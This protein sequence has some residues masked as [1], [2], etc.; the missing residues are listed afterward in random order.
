MTHSSFFS[1][2][3]AVLSGLAL[4]GLVSSTAYASS[5]PSAAQGQASPGRVTEQFEDRFTPSVSPQVEVT[6]FQPVGAPAN[7]DQISLTLN[8]LN[9]EGV[10]VYT[11][12]DL[13]AIYGNVLGQ[14]ITLADLYGIANEIT[15]RYRNDGFILTQAIIPP[16]TIDG[17]T[18]TIRVVEGFVDSVVVEGDPSITGSPLIQRMANQISFDGALNASDLERQLLL[19]NDLPGVSARSVLSPSPTVT[20]AADLRL[21][22]ER[23]PFDGLIGVD[24]YGSRYLGPLQTTFIGSANNFFLGFNERLTGQLVLAPSPE[25]ELSYVALNYEQPIWSHGTML[26]IFLS[27]T[28]TEP[29]F[30]LEQF[31]VE[32]ES[33]FVSVQVEHPFVRSRAFN[34]YGRALLDWRDVETVNNLND[35]RDDQIVAARIGT[36]VDFLDT[37]L[38]VAFN[39]LDVELAHGLD[40]L[41][42]TDDGSTTLSRPDGEPEFFKISGEYQR[43]QNVTR[44]INVLLG[45]RGQWT[46]EAL[47]SS[48]EFGFGGINYGRGFDSS[49]IIGDRGVAGKLE[50]Q[51]D[52]PIQWNLVQDYQ[53]FGFFDAGRVWND[54]ATTSSFK[55]DSATSVG[56]GVRME[57][58]EETFADFMIAKP[59]NRDVETTD[60]DD[61][62]F[63]FSLRREF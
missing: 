50:I 4:A 32:G 42:A 57:F 16:Q 13:E 10:T 33:N 24:N 36:R 52:Q 1:T 9:F 19:I 39:T 18:A 46:D 43:L 38:G 8:S 7:A 56:L 61:P 49:E 60:D 12:S 5:L 44:S 17:G 35:D 55:R 41:G 25:I 40:I 11:A 22:I 31:E 30:D 48:E 53:V 29:G 23:D 45:L 34:W 59:L 20:G 27:R 47:L 6:E 14:T 21:I 54:D 2:A 26:D 63:F 58:M 62:R 3:K 51:V 15:L 37:L 28:D